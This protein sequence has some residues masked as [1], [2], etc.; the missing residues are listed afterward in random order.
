MK[1]NR[2][3]ELTMGNRIDTDI[4]NRIDKVTELTR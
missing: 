2:V 3:T 4:G 1:F